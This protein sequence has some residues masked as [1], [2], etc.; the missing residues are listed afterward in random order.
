[1]KTRNN[2]ILAAAAIATLALSSTVQAVQKHDPQFSVQPI[3]ITS[4]GSDPDMVTH[5]RY[6]SCSPHAR[7][8]WYAINVTGSSADSRNLAREARD[9]NGSPHAKVDPTFMI[10]PLK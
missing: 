5:L 10:A 4:A 2:A 1:M 7:Q 8:D 9:Q 3:Y 6:Q